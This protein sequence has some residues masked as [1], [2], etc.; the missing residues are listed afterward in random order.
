MRNKFD[1]TYLSPGVFFAVLLIVLLGMDFLITPFDAAKACGP[2]SYWAV[3]VAFILILPLIWLAIALKRRF[4]SR[5]ILQIAPQVLSKPIALL[6]NL[7]FLS[8]FLIHI[9]IILRNATELVLIHL[10]DRTPPYMIVIF[11]LTGIGYVAFN[12]LKAVSRLASFVLIPTVAFRTLMKFIALQN[13]NMTHLLPIFSAPP[14]NYLMGGIAVTSGFLPLGLLFIIYPTLKDPAKL[15]PI[16]LI[17]AVI[18]LFFLLL[19]VIGTIGVYGAPLTIKFTWPIFEEIRHINMPYLVLEEVGLLFL[20]VWF[21]MFFVGCS[22][23]FYTLAHGLRQQFPLL[24]Y[25]WTVVGLVL[26]VGAGALAFPDLA[27]NTAWFTWFR[28][29]VIAPLIGYPLIV[30]LGALLRG[31]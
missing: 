20:I 6:G 24:N 8:L 7:V 14:I 13:M 26:L 3:F 19:A 31:I 11:F 5:N 23:Y 21:T 18:M 16:S 28:S 25:Q 2:S 15:R 1:I 29:W 9:I 17:C 10:L 27:T 4:P 12:G 30:Y 22:V